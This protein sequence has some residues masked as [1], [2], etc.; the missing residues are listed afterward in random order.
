MLGATCCA[1]LATLLRHVAGCW[2][3]FEAGQIWANSTQ[4]VATHRN[5]VAKRTQHVAP[6]NVAICW[7][8]ML[9]SFGRGF[10]STFIART[11]LSG[12]DVYR[13][14]LKQFCSEQLI[15]FLESF[16]PYEFT[17][18]PSLKCL[19]RASF[20]LP[21]TNIFSYVRRQCWCSLH[22]CHSHDCR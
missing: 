7:V 20:R 19:G 10:T 15:C 5:T 8:G 3:K 6:N 14:F 13:E 1:R 2:L 22:L 9:R 12:V 17:I 4:H 11:N 21:L 16:V 18:L